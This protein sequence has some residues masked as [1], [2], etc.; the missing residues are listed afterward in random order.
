MQLQLSSR[1]SNVDRGQLLLFFYSFCPQL[2]LLT[3]YTLERKVSGSGSSNDWNSTRGGRTHPQASKQEISHPGPNRAKRFPGVHYRP[4]SEHLRAPAPV[5]SE[6]DIRTFI[7]HLASV[8]FFLNIF[9]FRWVFVFASPLDA[10][11]L[12]RNSSRARAVRTQDGKKTWTYNPP[13]R[14]SCL[15]PWRLFR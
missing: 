1:L 4:S 6:L 3:R 9:Y 12:L 10:V 13:T 7:N 5:C 14:F 2:S 8:C 11:K 15:R